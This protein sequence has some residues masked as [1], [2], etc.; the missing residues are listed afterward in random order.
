M[1]AF[2]CAITDPDLYRRYAEPGIL[3]AAEP[4]S[5]VLPRASAGTLFRSYNVLL[6]EVAG[7]EDLEALV[8]VHQD[9]E[10]VDSDLCVKLRRSFTDPDVAAVGCAGAIGVRSIAWWEG[11]ITWG[12]FTHRY[13]EWGGGDID[14]ISWNPSET[15]PYAHTGEVD[16]IDGFVMALSPWAVRELRF[17]ESLGQIHGYDFDFCCQARAA[18]KKVVTADFRAIHHHSLELIRNTRGWI[19]AHR[20]VAEKWD[21]RLTDNPGSDWRQRALQAEAEAAAARMQV[22]VQ[23]HVR[24]AIERELATV[25][26]SRSW[27]LTA[28][29]RSLGR[30]LRR[31][32]R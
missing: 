24:D 2:G 4:D 15:P 22:I 32:R 11:S 16:T 8:L 27:R 19:E 7:R 3:R 30:L 13:E 10:I 25:L 18:G 17:D 9:A 5:E 31:R 14:A 29:G 1:I 20:R 12:G 6:E 21:G 28:P 26:G 23:D